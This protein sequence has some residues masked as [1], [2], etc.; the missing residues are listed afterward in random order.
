MRRLTLAVSVVAMVVVIGGCSTIKVSTDYDT[1]ADF[2]Q[3]KSYDW[4][5]VS[6][7]NAQYEMKDA[8]GAPIQ[9]AV[10]KELT[11]KGMTKVS[12]N[13]DVLLVYHTGKETRIDIERWG[14]SYG[15]RVGMGGELFNYIYDIGTLVVD[16]VDA[17][18]KQLLWRGAAESVLP[19]TPTPGQQS[20]LI[21]EAVAKIFAKFPPA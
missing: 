20:Q 13:P 10:D 14:Y 6:E 7:E 11:S 5:K 9:E 15:P 12:D 2:A 1:D 21:N 3:L 17:E 4:M 8:L 16:I 18:K 19:D